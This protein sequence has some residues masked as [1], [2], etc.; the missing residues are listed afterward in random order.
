[1]KTFKI[2][3]CWVSVVLITFF[4]T[5]ALINGTAFTI[6]NQVFYGY[7][8]VGGWQVISMIVHAVNGWFTNRRTGAR[9]IYHW[10]VVIALVTFP[11]GSFFILLFTAPFMAVGYTALCCRETWYIMH[12]P[13]SLL[14]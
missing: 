2:I 4:T 10:I 14:K 12:R 11:A 9:Y 1:M 6:N 3:D 5:M 13:L 7:F 8:A